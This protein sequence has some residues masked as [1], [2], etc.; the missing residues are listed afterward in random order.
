MNVGLAIKNRRKSLGLS[1]LKLALQ[2]NSDSAYICRVENNKKDISLRVFVRIALALKI[3]PSELL[4]IS[5][6]LHQNGAS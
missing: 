2:I 5:M 6:G 1:Q 3:K 4:E